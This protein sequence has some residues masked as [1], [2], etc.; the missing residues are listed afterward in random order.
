MKGCLAVVEQDAHRVALSAAGLKCRADAIGR[1][2]KAI[3]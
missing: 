1:N 3:E 2:R